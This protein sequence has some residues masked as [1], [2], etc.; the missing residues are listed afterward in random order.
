MSVNCRRRQD[1]PTPGSRE[2]EREKEGGEGGEGERRKRPNRR[3]KRS[4]RRSNKE[5][6]EKIRDAGKIAEGRIATEKATRDACRSGGARK[7]DRMV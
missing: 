5:D 2:G 6:R 3:P 4:L 7:D 1:L